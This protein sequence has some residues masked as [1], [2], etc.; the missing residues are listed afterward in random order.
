L[1]V[2]SD[3]AVDH[4][5]TPTL[6]FNQRAGALGLTITFMVRAMTPTTR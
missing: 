6:L 3:A 2:R 1:L 4:D 5:D